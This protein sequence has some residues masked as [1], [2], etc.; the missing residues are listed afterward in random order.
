PILTKIQNLPGLVN[1][2]VFTVIN[3][4]PDL[5]SLRLVGSKLLPNTDSNNDYRIFKTLL[6]TDNYGDVNGDGEIDQLDIARASQLV[7][8]SLFFESTQ[9]K[10]ID[11]DIQTLELLR[12]DVNGDGYITSDD[13]TIIT[14]YVSRSINSFPAGSTF[15][16]LD[17]YVQQSI[18][19]FDGYHDCTDG[20]I[21]L[22]GSV[23]A[24]EVN[25]E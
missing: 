8:E 10:I 14:N 24:N 5:L 4:D 23:G 19:R 17:I 20:Y 12:A 16:H 21:R 6:C 1:G 2:N 13:V 9:Q 25:S 22:D 7:G 18:G 11:G 15:Q 3:P